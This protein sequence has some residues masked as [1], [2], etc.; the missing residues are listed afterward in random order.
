M[1]N[2]RLCVQI[3]LCIRTLKL[4]FFPKL[5]EKSKSIFKMIF[6]YAFFCPAQEFFSHKIQCPKS[7]SEMK[8]IILLLVCLSALDIT[9]HKKHVLLRKMGDQRS[10]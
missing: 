7:E 10:T 9:I 8:E 6:V 5:R 3:V 1:F 2:H 4:S